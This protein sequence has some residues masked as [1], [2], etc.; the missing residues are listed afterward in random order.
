LKIGNAKRPIGVRDFVII[1]QDK[2]EC[3]S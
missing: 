3:W 2:I 1:K